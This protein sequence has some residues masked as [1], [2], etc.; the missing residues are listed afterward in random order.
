MLVLLLGW[1]GAII[2][3]LCA[4][5][6]LVRHRV[7]RH[8]RVDPKVATEAPLTWVADPRAAARLHRRLAKVG[9]AATAVADDH[10]LPKKR[11]RT[12]EQPP[13]VAVAEDLRHQAVRLDREVTRVAMLAPQARRQPLAELATA[14]AD[15][16]RACAQLVSL[17]AEIRTPPVLVTDDADITSVAAQVERLTEA[18][19]QLLQLDADAGL[20][21]QPSPGAT[22]QTGR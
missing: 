8:H 7:Q 4:A 13:M 3:A 12:A 20:V 14:V 17:S 11:L 16:E 5:A 2:V 10:R 18:H 21:P 19:R 1:T 22:L 15:T 9:H 6:M